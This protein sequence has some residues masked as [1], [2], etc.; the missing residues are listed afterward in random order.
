MDE[1][2]EIEISNKSELLE[3]LAGRSIEAEWVVTSDMGPEWIGS[4]TEFSL[5]LGEFRIKECTYIRGLKAALKGAIGVPETG[6][7]RIISGEAEIT[8]TGQQ[9]NVEYCWSSCVPYMDADRTVKGEV[10]L[11]A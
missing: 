5:Y 3:H 7:D 4:K 10:S 1:P 9:L 11:N 6:G 8:A 2:K